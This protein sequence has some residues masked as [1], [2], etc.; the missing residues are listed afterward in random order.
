MLSRC[1]SASISGL[2]AAMVEVETNTGQGVPQVVI[3]GL[4]DKAVTESRDRVKTALENC[5]FRHIRTRTTINL[6]PA[7]LRK[8]GPVYDL[9]MALGILAATEQLAMPR[10]AEFLIVGELALN[11]A[12]RPTRGVL[13]MAMLAR[14]IGRAGVIVPK[15]NAAEASLVQGLEVY[16]AGNL[17]E[18]AEFLANKIKLMPH[19]HDTDLL[20]AAQAGHELDFS[21]IKGQSHAK[22]AMEIAMA[23]GHNVLL[24]G[25]PGSGKSMLSRRLPT[26]APPMTLDEALETTRIHSVAGILPPSQPM[27]AARPF[28]SPHHTMSD[29]A[30]TGGTA[31]LRP[32]EVSLAHHGMLFLDELP[33]FKR[34]T[35]EALR[36]PIEDGAIH[37]ARATGAVAFP[38]RFMLVA[39]MNPCPCGYYGDPGKECRC[40]PVQIQRYRSK[41]SGPL[42]DRIDL[43]VEV[44][45]IPY[46]EM[47]R[48]A[49]GE[50]SAAIRDRVVQARYR[51]YQRYRKQGQTNAALGARAFRAHCQPD[52]SG[53][54]FLRSAVTEMRFSARA[55]DRILKVARTIADLDASEQITTRHIGEALQH[56]ALDRSI[57]T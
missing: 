46:T 53:H 5:G 45:A 51:Q 7:N 40:S 28:R 41:I 32:G 14:E 44:P 47:T 10:L 16:G 6:A 8:E 26:I 22:R 56:R 13:S 15:Q 37:V 39:A 17:R 43:H 27:V 42:L 36:Q 33:E 19:R 55:Y 50:T 25:P 24:I 31:D 35:L 4:P 34:S 21:D 52:E 30:L 2:D 48:S 11:G 3:V 38:C 1:F 23:G 49:P 12:L 18:C 20:L 54:E 29:I 9:P 57:W